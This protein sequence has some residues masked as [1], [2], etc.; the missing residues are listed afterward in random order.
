VTAAMPPCAQSVE[1]ESSRS[2]DSTAIFAY[3]ARC[4]AAESP[5]APLPMINTSCRLRSPTLRVTSVTEM[6]RASINEDLWAEYAPPA[7][8]LSPSL[9]GQDDVREQNEQSGHIERPW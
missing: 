1:P 3:G 2:F 7:R 9:R 6:V 8:L 4:S 5:A